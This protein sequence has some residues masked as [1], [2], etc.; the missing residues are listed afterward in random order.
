LKKFYP[1]ASL[2]NIIPGKGQK[3][4]IK[5]QTLAL[6][7]HQDK[8][9]AIQNKCP[10]QDAELADGYLMNNKLHC[11]LHHWAFNLPEGSYAFNPEMRLKTYATKIEKGMIY[12]G[13]DD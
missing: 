13:L 1:V 6:F 10:H 5:S 2:N 7:M 4:K 3:V 11:S 9:Y 8:I 12:V